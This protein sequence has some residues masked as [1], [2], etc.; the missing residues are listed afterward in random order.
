MIEGN[1]VKI[2]YDFRAFQ[3]FYQ[4]G[5]ARYVEDL[6]MHAI[7]Q[8]S[9]DA[10]ILLDKDKVYPKI[11][12]ELEGKIH[13]LFVDDFAAGDYL[14]V[15]FDVYIQGA[16]Y[17]TNLSSTMALPMLYPLYVI[18]QCR[19]KTGI[20]YDFIPLFF[21]DW[22][23]IPLEGE[24]ITYT[25]SIEIL[26]YFDHI[27]TD[28][29]CTLTLAMNYIKRK[30]E[31]FTCLYG[32][33]E[34]KKFLTENSN[35][36]YDTE[37]RSHNLIYISGMAKHK[38]NEGLIKAFCKVY[39]TKEIPADS[40]L[41][42][43]CKATPQ[44]IK[45]CKIIIESYG[46]EHGKQVEVTGYLKDDEM[47]RLLMNARASI[48]PSFY[49]GLGLPILESYAAGTPCWASN[50]SSTREI[51]LDECSFDPFDEI[52]IV[53]TIKR[54]YSSDE[55]CE[56]SLEYGRNLIE[57]RMNWKAA[58]DTLLQQLE[59]LCKEKNII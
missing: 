54:I 57:T 30:K 27:F 5:V 55:L 12:K 4:R 13:F 6:F 33:A 36:S 44:F 26:K 34:Y 58:A 35:K 22:K 39:Q 52:S 3:V 46:L 24:K 15:W 23:K 11:P 49:E 20:L 17:W 1:R 19:I 51:V 31:D 2:L 53:N 28:S 16:C 21:R 48:F 56:K 29:M 10:Y 25:I 8:H 41:Y 42:I 50:V 18:R 7:S 40:K 9:S 38:N 47:V 59:K 32:G 37:N 14:D 45:K 43:V